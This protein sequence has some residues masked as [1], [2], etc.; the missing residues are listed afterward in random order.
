MDFPYWTHKKSKAFC[1]VRGV[2]SN[3]YWRL[4]Q[5]SHM[6]GSDFNFCM[7]G[8]SRRLATPRDMA[9]ASSGLPAL[10]LFVKPINHPQHL[11]SSRKGWI[12][13]AT[14]F[15]WRSGSS[16][17][18][19]LPTSVAFRYGPWWQCLTLPGVQQ[20]GIFWL[21]PG[22][23]PI[24]GSS[25][26]DGVGRLLLWGHVLSLPKLLDLRKS[27]RWIQHWVAACEVLG[28]VLRQRKTTHTKCWEEKRAV[29][30][31]IPPQ[32]KMRLHGNP[33]VAMVSSVG[34]STWRR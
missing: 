34:L 19:G 11:G 14:T 3:Q 4:A 22:Q 23:T 33:D 8:M 27:T 28:L 24:P 17:C 2:N 12:L 25:R 10:M 29:R 21:C 15:Q 1:G 32:V 26:P 6:R 30:E 31:G 5:Y 16:P 20:V 13:G 18:N 7:P 9:A